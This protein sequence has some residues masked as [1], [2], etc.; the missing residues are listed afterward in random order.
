MK[1]KH[2]SQP[3]DV[4]RSKTELNSRY[5]LPHTIPHQTHPTHDASYWIPPGDMFIIM[6]VDQLTYSD[7]SIYT[8]AH[9]SGIKSRVLNNLLIAY[10]EKV[11]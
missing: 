5:F 9:M 7:T 1:Y 3:G 8:L 10:F 2:N 4:V 11:D 6:S